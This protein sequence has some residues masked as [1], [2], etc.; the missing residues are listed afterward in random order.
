MYQLFRYPDDAG[1]MVLVATFQTAEDVLAWWQSRP[2]D[3]DG[4]QHI[5]TQK[6]RVIAVES[7][8]S[9]MLVFV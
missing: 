8:R 3:S 7:P 9:R 1:P 6:T 2:A 4:Q 5:L